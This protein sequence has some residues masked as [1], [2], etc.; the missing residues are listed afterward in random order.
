MKKKIFYSCLF[1]IFFTE[2]YTQDNIGVRFFGLSF[3][4]KGERENAHLM[5]LKYDKNAYF[6]QNLG[7]IVS[8]ENFFTKIDFLIKL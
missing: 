5:T 2:G 7:G 6:V 3:H 8:Y 4:P 1:F